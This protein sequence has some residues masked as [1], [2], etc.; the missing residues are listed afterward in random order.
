[1]YALVRLVEVILQINMVMRC[2]SCPTY[3][4]HSRFVTLN[5]EIE[6]EEEG[7]YR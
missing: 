6:N 5:I 2:K 3:W 7:N 1:M 4:K